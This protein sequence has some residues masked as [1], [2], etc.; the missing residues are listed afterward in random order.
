MSEENCETSG[1]KETES[2]YILELEPTGGRREIPFT[3]MGA[4]GVGNR[5]KIGL[6]NKIL[7]DIENPR[8]TSKGC[9]VLLD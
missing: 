7:V 3:E 8:E 2:G 5:R 9:L 6:E 4:G 1:K